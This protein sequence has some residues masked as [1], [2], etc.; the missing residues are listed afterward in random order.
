MHR[1]ARRRRGSTRALSYLKGVVF[2]RGFFTLW[3]LNFV[4]SQLCGLAAELLRRVLGEVRGAALLSRL[5][6]LRAAR[7]YMC[8]YMYVTCVYMYNIYVYYIFLSIYIYIYIYT[9]IHI[10]IYIY[11]YIYIYKHVEV[12]R[13]PE[14]LPRTL[15]PRGKLVA[16][17]T[18]IT[19]ISLNGYERRARQPK[20]R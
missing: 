12:G 4:D 20:R 9:Y 15:N 3:I 17:S 8:R 19:Y 11:I 16:P 18:R 10:H 6:S 5:L 7:P 1:C 14:P 13:N 2:P